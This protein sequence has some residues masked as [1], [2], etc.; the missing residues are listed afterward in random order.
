MK[1]RLKRGAQAMK[2]RKRRQQLTDVWRAVAFVAGSVVPC[3]RSVARDAEGHG[4]AGVT[5]LGQ[6]ASYIVL[7]QCKTITAV[8]LR[9]AED[10]YE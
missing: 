7:C 10:S 4:L 3:K 5:L 9:R 8:R 2:K 6:R 1:V